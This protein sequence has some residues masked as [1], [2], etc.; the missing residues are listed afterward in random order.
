MVSKGSFFK[1]KSLVNEIIDK[2]QF[3]LWKENKNG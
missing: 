3:T 2:I 1:N